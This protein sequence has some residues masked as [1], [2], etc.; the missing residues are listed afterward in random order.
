MYCVPCE[1]FYTSSQLIDGKCPECRSE[2]R[3]TKEEAYFLK[4]SKYQK[5]LEEHILKNPD[6]IYPES[7][8]REMLNNFIKPGLQDLCVSRTSFKWGVPVTFDDKHIIYVWVDALSNYI[9]A[10]G[11]DA[12]ENSKL[13][14][15]Y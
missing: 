9:T 6:F 12:K 8:K 14:Y 2:V 4:L 10:L 11:F 1:G 15:K 3:P 5:Q 7:R 13:Y